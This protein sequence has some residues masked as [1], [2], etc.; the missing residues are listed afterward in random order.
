MWGN[1]LLII[2]LACCCIPCDQGHSRRFSVMFC[3]VLYAKT[4]AHTPNDW[5][6][7]FNS[8][9][10]VQKVLLCVFLKKATDLAQKIVLV[11]TEENIYRDNWGLSSFTESQTHTIMSGRLKGKWKRCLNSTTCGSVVKIKILDLELF[12]HCSIVRFC[13]KLWNITH[14]VQGNRQLT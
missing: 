7:P 8:G 11:G 1:K 10:F 4:A 9:C 14:S 2:H 6:S 12:A 13:S 3:A 5:T